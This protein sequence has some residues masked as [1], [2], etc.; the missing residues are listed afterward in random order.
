MTRSPGHGIKTSQ[1]NESMYPKC[2]IFN[3]FHF[4]IEFFLGRR[5][6][7]VVQILYPTAIRV[8]FSVVPSSTLQSRCVTSQLVSLP[9]VDIY[10]LIW[11]CS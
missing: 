6:G 7:R 9:P 11:L 4:I 10:N 5:S 3:M 8:L 1:I 2:Q